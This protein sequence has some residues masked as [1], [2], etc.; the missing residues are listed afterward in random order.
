MSPFPKRIL[1]EELEAAFAEVSAPASPERYAAAM[2]ELTLAIGNVVQAIRHQP[3][4]KS[5]LDIH[6][7]QAERFHAAGL[8]AV[9]RQFPAAVLEG[10]NDAGE[11]LRV[12]V[13]QAVTDPEAAIINDPERM[14]DACCAWVRKTFDAFRASLAAQLPTLRGGQ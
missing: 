7:F 11:E 10:I 2:G 8:E 1:T 9:L 3:A 14:K 5:P 4:Y 6:P 13:D 12:L